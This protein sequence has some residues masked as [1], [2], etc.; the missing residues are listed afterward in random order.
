MDTLPDIGQIE[1]IDIDGL[2]IRIARSGRSDGTPIILTSPWP[3]S[4]Y[5]FRDTAPVLAALGPVIAVDLPGFGRSEGRASLIAPEAMGHFLIGLIKTLG[6]SRVHAVGPDVGTLAL[7]FAAH[8]RPDLFESLVGGSGATDANL[9]GP[10]L[11]AIIDSP[12]GYFETMDGGDIAVSFVTQ[13]A[14]HPTPPAVL[15]DYRLSS[16]GRRFEDAARFVRAYREELPRLQAL[17]PTVLTPVLVQA[18]RHDPG[19]PPANGQLLADHLPH[20]RHVLLEGG[21]LVWEDAAEAY[22]QGVAAWIAGGYR[23]V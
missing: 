19:V 9:A 20:S 14:A 13:S 2:Q 15:E 5:A 10:E 17:L 7:L 12:P 3:E 21:H 6:F 16:A 1:H 4:L 23:E 8:H 22:A 18:G 11:R